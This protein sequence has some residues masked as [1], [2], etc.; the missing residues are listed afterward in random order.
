ML[1]RTS[2]LGFR[3]KFNCAG[4]IIQCLE[5]ILLLRRVPEDDSCPNMYGNPAGHSRDG[6]CFLATAIRETLEETGI[7]LIDY[8]CRF[9]YFGNFFVRY[10]E[11]DFNYELYR[12][13]LDTKPK[14]TLNPKEHD[15]YIWTPPEKALLL[16]LVPDFDE[17]LR[18]VYKL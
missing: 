5:D 11:S 14:V 3:P 9:K 18:I 13:N 12:L 6:E 2:P 17:V 7:N 15:S 4:V 10:E 1:Y 16:P 8:M